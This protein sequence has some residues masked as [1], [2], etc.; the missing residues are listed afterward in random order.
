MPDDIVTTLRFDGGLRDNNVVL[1]E[2]HRYSQLFGYM[3][4]KRIHK[5]LSDL[6]L[7]AELR[8][9]IHRDGSTPM[10]VYDYSYTDG[11]E[12]E[13]GEYWS[14]KGTRGGGEIVIDLINQVV[15]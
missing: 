11:D 9:G 4:E 3:K 7:K 12:Y 14:K 2:V 1:Y 10:R 15:D 13:I 5:T 6:N 8:F